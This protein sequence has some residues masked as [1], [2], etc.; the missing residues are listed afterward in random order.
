[1]IRTEIHVGSTGEPL[2]VVA[3]RL[4]EI[5]KDAFTIVPS[6]GAWEGIVEP[7]FVVRFDSDRIVD[8]AIAARIRD[9]Y[10]QQCVWV[11]HSHIEGQLV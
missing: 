3:K 11:T 8:N 10:A 1:M 2:D 7:A 4:A 5:T 6:Y 9:A